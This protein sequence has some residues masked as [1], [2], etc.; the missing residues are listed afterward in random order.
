[1]IISSIRSQ[2][3]YGIITA[4]GRFAASMKLKMLSL[5]EIYDEAEL[6]AVATCLFS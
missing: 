3:C 4:V 1:M 5:H 2:G 6:S